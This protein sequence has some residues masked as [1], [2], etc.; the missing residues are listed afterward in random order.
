MRRRLEV[1]RD[2]TSFQLAIRERDVQTATDVGRDFCAARARHAVEC[3][4]DESLETDALMTEL[5][6][7]TISLE[8]E[9]RMLASQLGE[10]QRV[11]DALPT[12]RDRTRAR[13]IIEDAMS[14]LGL[15]ARVRL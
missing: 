1:E 10:C 8:R 15:P 9:R 12:E 11:A 7:V 14:R 3:L 5:D 2:R 6:L 4:K 13:R